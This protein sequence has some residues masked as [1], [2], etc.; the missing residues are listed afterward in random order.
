MTASRIRQRMRMSAALGFAMWVGAGLLAR[1]ASWDLNLYEWLFLLAPLVV[2]PLA[3][4]LL[5]QGSDA[6]HLLIA[7]CRLQPLAAG[8]AVMSFA[9]PPGALAAAF[10]LP[11]LSVCGLVGLTGLAGLQKA[12][13]TTASALGSLAGMLYLPVGAAALTLSRAGIAPLHFTE[14][15]VLLTAVHFHFTGFATPVFAAS[16][17]KAIAG[18]QRWAGRRGTLAAA[19]LTLIAATPLLAIGWLLD[20]PPW[21]LA[22]VLLLV[23]SVS[24]LAVL[25]LRLAF[26][27]GGVLPRVLLGVSAA[28]VLFGM[29]LAG[30]YGAGEFGGHSLIGLDEMAR[31]HGTANGVGFSL[32]G[33]LSMNLMLEGQR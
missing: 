22:C 7:P 33:L 24:V 25:S 6:P 18:S 19:I 10:T 3:L 20:S 28:A 4:G 23:G 26:A 27:P 32:C 21:K 1:A 9:S 13:P 2:V 12:R 30:L 15:I 11:W 29:V 16:L 8:I 17:S 31:L 14:P 5:L